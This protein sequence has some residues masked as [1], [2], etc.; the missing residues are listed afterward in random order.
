MDNKRVRLAIAC[1][2]VLALVGCGE[3]RPPAGPP[4]AKPY[5]TTGTVKLADGSLLKGGIVTFTPVDV[6]DSGGYV[7]Y[8]GS[9]LVDAQGRYKVGFN[10][11]DAG[12]AAGE[13]KVSVAPRDYQELK[14]SNSSRIPK[15]FQ[16]SGSTP[17]RRT[18]KEEDN[19]FNLELK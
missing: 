14:G 1:G 3:N 13:Y 10:A 17:L 11:N 12:V 9:G 8:E 19:V 15:I 6:E 18:V 2:L 5:L 4:L 16:S 7:R